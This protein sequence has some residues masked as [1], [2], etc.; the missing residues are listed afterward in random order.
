MRLDVRPAIS[1]EQ[2][3]E[4]RALIDALTADLIDDGAESIEIET[5]PPADGEV[6]RVVV[7][8]DRL[9]EPRVLSVRGAE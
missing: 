5:A 2:R 7:K 1:V 8:S 9:D 3:H 4:L 6:L